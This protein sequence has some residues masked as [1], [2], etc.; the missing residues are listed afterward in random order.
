MALSPLIDSVTQPVELRDEAMRTW[1]T[2]PV[3]GRVL[4]PGTRVMSLMVVLPTTPALTVESVRVTLP[5][6][7]I[8][9]FPEERSEGGAYQGNG[10][11][12]WVG[13]VCEALEIWLAGFGGGVE[14]D[15]CDVESLQAIE[16]YAR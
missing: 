16:T 9:I 4:F 1:S 5:W 12:G 14:A 6:D 15:T 3:M 10:D 2:M 11:D 13:D 8:S 7:M